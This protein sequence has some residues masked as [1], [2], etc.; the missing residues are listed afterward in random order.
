V[1]GRV[2]PG[3]DESCANSVIIEPNHSAGFAAA[4]AAAAARSAATRFSTK[5]TDKIEPS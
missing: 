2:K 1:D 3:H 5:R 4:E